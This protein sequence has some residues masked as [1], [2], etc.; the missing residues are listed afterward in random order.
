MIEREDRVAPATAPDYARRARRA[1]Q[2]EDFER[3]R[4]LAEAGLALAPESP[5]LRY[6]LS[7]AL[8]RLAESERALSVLESVDD[9][10]AE[11]MVLILTLRARLLNALGRS[12]EAFAFLRQALEIDPGNVEAQLL[13]SSVALELSSYYLRNRRF[14]EAAAV[15]DLALQSPS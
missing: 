10:P 7:V 2:D 13:R 6:T 3:A 14:A 11:L 5:I 12:E 9:A 1:A 8:A 15:A 4:E